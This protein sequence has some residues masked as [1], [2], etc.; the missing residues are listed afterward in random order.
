MELELGDIEMI[1]LL[2]ENPGFERF[3][4]VQPEVTKKNRDEVLNSFYKE[5]PIAYAHVCR[6]MQRA[7][8]GIARTAKDRLHFLPQD[9]ELEMAGLEFRIGPEIEMVKTRLA[10]TG[11]RKPGAEERDS[12]RL[13]E[14]RAQFD[15]LDDRYFQRKIDLEERMNSADRVMKKAIDRTLDY[16]EIDPLMNINFCEVVYK[17]ALI[18]VKRKIDDRN[19]KRMKTLKFL[20]GEVTGI[21]SLFA[22]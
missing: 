13:A 20:G 10:K 2:A 14:L 1:N 5:F 6:K 15:L 4:S 16:F 18:A 19:K 7:H 12:A 21:A 17:T 3:I 9:K 8:S 11:K 22:G